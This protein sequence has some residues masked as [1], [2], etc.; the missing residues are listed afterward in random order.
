[1]HILPGLL[2]LLLLLPGAASAAPTPFDRLPGEWNGTVSS[3]DGCDWKVRASISSGG[4]GF[5]GTFSYQG[6]CAEG[7]R[8][9]EF[10]GKNTSKSCFSAT[11]KVEGM[12]PIPMTGCA[13]KKGNITFKTVGF[14]GALRFL[15]GN[16]TLKLT[17]NAGQGNAKGLFKRRAGGKRAPAKSR[18]AAGAVKRGGGE[19]RQGQDGRNDEKGSSEVLIGGY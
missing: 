19:G 17:V 7:A 13:D 6:D 8:Q 14:D 10:S 15:K 16:N 5:S 9:G 3:D 18:P 4:S 2:T 1:M 12:P 11:A